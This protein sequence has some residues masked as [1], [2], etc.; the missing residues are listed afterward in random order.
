MLTIQEITS[1]LETL[2][3]LSSQESYDNCGLIVGDAK[4][5]VDAAIVTLDCTEEVIL[6]A[7][8]RGISL[9]IAHHPIVFNGLKKLNGKNYVERA[10]IT[11][12]KHEIAIYAIHTNLDNFNGGVNLEIGTRLGLQHLK[13]LQPKSRALH[14]LVVFCP[15]EAAATVSQA[16]FDAG[17]GHIGNYDQC[18]FETNG[19]GFFRPLDGAHPVLGKIGRREKV[20]ETRIEM[21]CSKHIVSRVISA[22][23]YAHPYEEVAYDC[24]QL[25]NLNSYEGAGMIGELTK[26]TPLLQFLN[27]VKS[28]FNCGV[29]RHT[30]SPSITS[31]KKVAFCGGSGAF[32]IEK[33]LA[34]QADIYI[35]GDLKYHEFFDAEDRIILADIGHYESEQFTPNLLKSILKKK[36]INFAV[37]FSEVKTNPVNYF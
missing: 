3:P 8:K 4:K 21:L 36:F 28:V 13:V 17:A 16:M 26:P 23:Q 5:T 7:K 30:S 9:V 35:T 29:I 18:S 1:Y 22:M 11:A 27:Q 34:E 24:Y 32:L 19:V 37:H 6:E 14:K 31:V 10:V 25:E 20:N 15:S 2:A 33:A 12:I